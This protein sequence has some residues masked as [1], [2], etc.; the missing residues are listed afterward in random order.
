M[1]AHIICDHEQTSLRIRDVL[2]F[3][4]MECPSSNVISAGAA[5]H[6]VSRETASELIVVAANQDHE[7]ILSLMPMLAQ[8]AAGKILAV[9][10]TT[11][12]KMMLQFLRAGASDFI[13]SG[14]LEL[15]LE[16]A[17][18]RLT[19][20]NAAPVEPGRLIVFL[21]PN[22]GSGS[23]TLAANVSAALAK[24]QGGVGLLDM[25]LETGDLATLLDIKPAFTLADLCQNAARLDRVM[26]ERSL[27]KHE[28]GIHVL[29][30]PLKLS[31][32][33]SVKADGVGQAM[34]LSLASFSHVVVDLDHSFR[35]EQLV[36]LRQADVIAVVMRLDFT[37]LRNVR[38]SL[39][40][41][42][43]LGLAR[44]KVRLVVN[45][46]GQPQEIPYGKV[47]EALGMKICSFIPED[48]KT[49]NRAN[50]QGVPV[51]L[52]APT[53]KVSRSIIQLAKAFERPAKPA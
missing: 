6:R 22:G 26:F 19:E 40:Y 5:A 32:I 2:T 45:R 44:E 48:S 10:P 33:Q 28:S 35:E 3:H 8:A 38:R 21:S 42:D 37:S 36:L 39:D 52:A 17:L 51:I 53:A 16:A 47:E 13:D 1:A 29:A 15:E 18:R 30:S 7:R 50:N 41:M 25:K 43:S 14:D 11:N 49:V 9:G 20:Q 31:E 27:V 12:S 23:S 24:T 4:G 46:Y 34:N